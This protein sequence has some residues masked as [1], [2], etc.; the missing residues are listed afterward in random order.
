MPFLGA[1]MLLVAFLWITL[2]YEVKV[3]RYQRYVPRA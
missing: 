2:P 1:L 3:G